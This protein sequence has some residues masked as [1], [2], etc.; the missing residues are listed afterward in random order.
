MRADGPSDNLPDKVRPVPPPGLKVE[1]QERA[2]LLAS[3]AEL[4]DRIETVRQE[5]KGRAPLLD[6]L[7]DVQVYQK[8]VLW[9]VAYDEIYKTNELSVARRLL[10]H[11]SDRLEELRQGKPAWISATGLV[12]RGY[13]SKIDGSVQPYGLVVPSSFRPESPVPYRLDFWFHG[14][15]ENLTELSFIQGRE[16]SAGEFTPRHAFVLHSYG[17][18]CNGNKFAGETDVFEALDHAARHYPI[19]QRRLV[20]RGFSL[21]GAACWHM[22]VHHAWR[23]AAAAPGAGFAETPEFLKVFQSEKLKPAWYEQK[24]WHLYDCTDWALN[25]FHCPTVAYSG[26]VDKQKQAADVMSTAMAREGLDLVHIIGPKTAHSYHPD[27]KVE[28]N[29]RI[30]AIVERG[31]QAVPPR[32]RFVT[33][34]LKYNRMNWVVVDGLEQHWEKAFVDADI[35]TSDNSVRVSTRNVS[36]LTLVFGP[37]EC[38]LDEVRPTRVFIDGSKPSSARVR[39]D[40]SWTA[41]FRKVGSRWESVEEEADDYSKLR[42]RHDL[43]GPI[44]DA[45]MDSFLVVRPTG[46]AASAAVGAWVESELAHA[47]NHWRQHFRGL[48][49]LKND[50][51]VNDADIAAHHLVL[52][53][54]PASN[55]L[56]KRIADKLPIQWDKK[57]VRVGK[58]TF[59]AAQHVP[60]MIYPNPLNP[61]KYVVLNSGFTFREYD[62]LNNARQVPKLPDYAVLNVSTPANSRWPGEVAT[63]GFF[64]EQWQLSA[65]SSRQR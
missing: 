5:L 54:D 8:A 24:L 56:L 36:A 25:L 27:A 58:E 35:G 3:A 22:A 49:R 42:K 62:Y 20:V 65:R 50:A 14:R 26:E 44:D 39:S 15:G 40:R 4:G 45:F 1:D 9:A 55:Q 6:L 28:I 52:W 10:Q 21:G 11:G 53:G 16:A 13:L 60:V 51:D 61:R 30:D 17:R 41:R 59:P 34:T 43:Q 32:V 63:A 19:D 29:K 12:V 37:G 18:F 33:W 64:D 31:S 46:P 38:P 47:T 48:A 23:W 2:Q 57:E 7:P